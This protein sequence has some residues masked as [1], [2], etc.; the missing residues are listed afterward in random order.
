MNAARCGV[1]SS[2]ILFKYLFTSM[3]RVCSVGKGKECVKARV[4]THKGA[5]Q[6]EGC[7]PQR[8]VLRRGLLPTKGRVKTRG[9]T[10]KGACQGKGWY[11]QRTQV[12]M[13]MLYEKASRNVYNI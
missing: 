11:S 2:V 7:Y 6:G 9:G 10:H 4:V 5:C 13:Y 12:R 8:G 1:G 3:H